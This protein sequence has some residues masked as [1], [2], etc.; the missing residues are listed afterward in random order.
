M[1]LE[2]KLAV[3]KTL[4]SSIYETAAWGKEDQPSFL[5]FALAIDTSHSVEEILAIA[6][7]IE[8]HF[9]RQRIELWGQRTLDIDILF[10]GKNCLETE[11]LT[12]PH[13]GIAQRRFVLVPMLEIAPELVHPFLGKTIN[14]LLEECEDGLDVRVFE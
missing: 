8:A 5:N 4:R 2:Q 14:E 3:G 10:F 6:Q 9:G 12:V 1:Q 11:V 7:D 13:P